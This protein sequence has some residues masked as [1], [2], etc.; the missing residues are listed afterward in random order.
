VLGDAVR[1]R[2]LLRYWNTW[3]FKHP[4]VN[5]L[6]R[7]MEK[8][9]GLELDWYK[10]Y[11]VNSTKT[12]DYAVKEVVAAGEGTS[13]TLERKGAMPMPIEVVVTYQDGSK[14][15]LYLP[16]EMMRGEKVAEAGSPVRVI[17]ED[18]PWTHPTKTLTLAKPFASIKSVE[19]DPSKRMAD[20]Q[21]ENNKVEF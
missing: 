19:I 10:E 14:E 20:I 11:F 2:G 1:D 17:S 15:M 18:W 8:E 21:P 9:S 16:L 12:I 3:Q 4:N 7:V 5:D 6:V 13:I